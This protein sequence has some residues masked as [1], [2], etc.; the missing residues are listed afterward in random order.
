M[1]LQLLRSSEQQARPLHARPLARTEALQ[2]LLYKGA[3][4]G[5]ARCAMWVA[6][7]RRWC[8]VGLHRSTNGHS[9]SPY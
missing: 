7:Q 5:L 8:A 1:L 4:L 6:V 3:L 9:V 2:F